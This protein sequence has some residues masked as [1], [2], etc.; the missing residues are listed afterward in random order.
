MINKV[1]GLILAGG[2]GERLWPLSRSTKPKQFL[3]IEPGITLLEQSIE[4]LIPLVEKQDI[5]IIAPPELATLLAQITPSISIITEPAAKNT[6]PALLWAC[7]HI[8]QET[9]DAMVVVCPADHAINNTQAFQEALR[10]A[11]ECANYTNGIT[12]LGIKPSFPATGYGYIQ[13]CTAPQPGTQGF[14]VYRFHEKPDAPYAQDYV[15][16]GYLWN[17]GIFIGKVAHFLDAF[18]VYAPELTDLVHTASHDPTAYATLPSISFD[19][20]VLEHAQNLFV[21]PLECQWSDLGNLE[22]FLAFALQKS[23][24]CAPSIEIR[25]HNNLVSSKQMTVLI[26]VESLCIV[27]TEDVLVIAKREQVEEIK[28]AVK[29]LQKSGHYHYL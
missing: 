17:S 25:A 16:K 18:E 29:H 28:Q 13:P 23:T 7:L 26:G 19:H 2:K 9:P 6:G 8:A 11:I 24:T 27:Q 20:A 15:Q 14:K 12:L 1:V 22:S 21:V 4:R 5:K 3:E 10:S